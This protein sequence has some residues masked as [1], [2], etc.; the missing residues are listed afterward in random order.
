MALR[1]ALDDKNLQDRAKLQKVQDFYRALGRPREVAAW[2][3]I[4]DPLPAA[5][6]GN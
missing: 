5:P 1:E 3:E 4:L 6:V 2:Q